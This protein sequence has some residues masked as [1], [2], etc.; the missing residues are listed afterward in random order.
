ML[1]DL[2]QY[3]ARGGILKTAQQIIE[4]RRKEGLAQ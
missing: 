1:V 2:A 4:D 3:L